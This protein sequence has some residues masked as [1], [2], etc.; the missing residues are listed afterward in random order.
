MD[1]D[2]RNRRAEERFYKVEPWAQGL[3][4]IAAGLALLYVSDR[5]YAPISQL[6]ARKCAPTSAPSTPGSI[7]SIR[8]S[9]AARTPPPSPNTTFPQLTSPHL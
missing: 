1:D 3:G 4:F 8:P 2:M 6:S 5:K 9:S 7:T